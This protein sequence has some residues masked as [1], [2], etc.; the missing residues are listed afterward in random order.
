M[1]KEI[2]LVEVSVRFFKVGE[3]YWSKDLTNYL[4]Q[5][6]PVTGRIKQASKEKPAFWDNFQ[7]PQDIYFK[8]DN[9]SFA[10]RTFGQGTSDEWSNAFD[11]MIDMMGIDEVFKGWLPDLEKLA[12][13]I[14]GEANEKRASLFRPEPPSNNINF[15]TAWQYH[16]FQTP[17]TS[18]G[19][20][21]WEEEWE[22]IGAV[23]LSKAPFAIMKKEGDDENDNDNHTR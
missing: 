7:T 1:T 22:L 13:F 15:V 11:W 21:E 23:G 12:M 19:G 14:L 6:E 16:G 3:P 5:T 8:A 10:F 18:Y 2:C 4:W 9:C 17:E 20:G